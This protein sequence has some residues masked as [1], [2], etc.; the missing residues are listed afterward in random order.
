[1]LRFRS[2]LAA[3]LRPGASTGP[4]AER[5]MLV[6]AKS[7]TAITSQ[8]SMSLRAIWWWKIA[9]LV[10]QRTVELGELPSG[11]AAVARPGPAAGEDPLRCGQLACSRSQ[12]PRVGHNLAVG[13][14][15]EPGDADIQADLPTGSR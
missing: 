5:V 14:R 2:A 10:G 6:I 15:C 12:E 8:V 1:M 7:S 4:D 9:P 11:A 3:T 13:G